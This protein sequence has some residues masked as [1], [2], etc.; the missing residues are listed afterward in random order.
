MSNSNIRIKGH[1]VMMFDAEGNSFAFGTNASI[2]IN[3]E[4]QD[5]KDKDTSIYGKKA[6]GNVTW[7][8]S[9]DH[10]LSWDEF[11]EWQQKAQNQTDA[12]RLFIWY[13]LRKG[14]Q[15]GPDE[16]DTTYGKLSYVNDGTDG[17]RVIDTNSYSLCGYVFIESLTQNSQDGEYGNYTVQFQGDGNL[18]KAKFTA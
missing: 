12:N 8:L 5:I 10:T 7:S 11:I 14:Y 13:G 16:T 15:G 2:S 18:T 9:S 17:H 1:D 6:P 3:C 4:I